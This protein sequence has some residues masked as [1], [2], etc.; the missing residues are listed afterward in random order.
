MHHYHSQ[1]IFCSIQNCIFLVPKSFH[2][3]SMYRKSTWPIWLQEILQHLTGSEPLPPCWYAAIELTRG[4]QLTVR[5][6]GKWAVTRGF[7]SLVMALVAQC[8]KC[9][10][11]RVATWLKDQ[12]VKCAYLRLLLV[13]SFVL[14]V[15]S[16]TC[17][18]FYEPKTGNKKMLR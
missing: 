15:E 3:V 1:T 5:P 7:P 2:L 8:T 6:T 14:I 16:W 13:F 11:F 18:F 12:I 17:S 9:Q 10:A 4:E